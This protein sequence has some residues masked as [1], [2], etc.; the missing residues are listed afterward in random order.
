MH[1]GF[2]LR[3][4]ALRSFNIKQTLKEMAK[5]KSVQPTTYR[6]VCESFRLNPAPVLRE[7]I[8]T[9]GA[10]TNL[11]R[12]SVVNSLLLKAYEQGISLV[13]VAKLN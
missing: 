5:E 13:P 9:E 8:N 3:I 1:F 2:L 11:D 10:A 4:F 7:W 12:P 6:R